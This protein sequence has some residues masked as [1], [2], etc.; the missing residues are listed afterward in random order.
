AAARESLAVLWAGTASS[1]DLVA[2]D[3]YALPEPRDFAELKAELATLPDLERYAADERLREAGLRLARAQAVADW[4]WS[5][6]VR[7]LE[8][9]GDQALVA[10]FSVPLGES[11]RARPVL[12]EAE[13]A[14]ARTALD[15]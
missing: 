2:L 3:L 7:H 6:G 9:S 15:R 4:R 12:R 1:D 5:I 8:E 11:R 14:R 13:L 10:G